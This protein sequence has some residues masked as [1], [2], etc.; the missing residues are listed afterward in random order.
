M[1]KTLIEIAKEQ[2]PA[3]IVNDMGELGVKLGERCFFLYK[4]S[5][6]EY[7]DGKHDD[8]TPILYRIVGKREF[9]E[10]QWPQ[11]WVLAGQREHRYTEQLVF[12]EGLSF[13]KPE[14]GDWMPLPPYTASQHN[15]DLISRDDA[16]Q[17]IINVGG[18][19]VWE[20]ADAIKCLKNDSRKDGI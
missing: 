3:W 1:T 19:R 16:I 13:G 4:G 2:E 14:D 18:K 9:G 20:F 15:Q 12:I 11:K 8:G 17:A 6:I 10:T 7:K 5:N